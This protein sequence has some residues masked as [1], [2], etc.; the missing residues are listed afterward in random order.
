[1]ADMQYS[2]SYVR[3][4]PEIEAR[5]LALIEEALILPNRA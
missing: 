1:M 4:A 5:K 2:T 3:E